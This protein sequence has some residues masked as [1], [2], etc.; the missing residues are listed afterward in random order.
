LALAVVKDLQVARAPATV[1]D[2]EASETDVLAWA[3]AGPFGRVDTR[4][5][6]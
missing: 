2:L 4:T 1:E 3:A 6:L 5:C